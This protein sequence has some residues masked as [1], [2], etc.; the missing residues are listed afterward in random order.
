MDAH[1]DIRAS[2]GG[3]VRIFTASRPLNFIY[4]FKGN[5]PTSTFINAA[6]NNTV[7]IAGTLY[8]DTATER[9]STYYPSSIGGTPY[10]IFYKDGP[11]SDT[12]L[13]LIRNNPN[14]IWPDYELFYKPF[15]VYLYYDPFIRHTK[16]RKVD[17]NEVFNEVNEYQKKKKTLL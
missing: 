13:V 7:Y 1:S 6:I 3:L 8:V 11:V 10:T 17:W 12:L 4:N 15:Y 9:W 5:P 2:G 14:I 16:Q